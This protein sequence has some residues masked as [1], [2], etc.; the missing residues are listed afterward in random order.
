MTTSAAFCGVSRSSVTGSRIGSLVILILSGTARTPRGRG[1]WCCCK[2]PRQVPSPSQGMGAPTSACGG[3]SD[4]NRLVA[5]VAPLFGAMRFA[6]SISLTVAVAADRQ[7]GEDRHGGEA[8][9][10]GPE[11]VT[12]DGASLG[13]GPDGV[14]GSG[15]GLDFG[16]G[17][18][19][20]RHGL[21]GGEHRAGEDQRED[22]EEASQ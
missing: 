7:G 22:R 17:L 18:Q 2:P 11:Q 5:C 13:E 4:T 9:C 20:A 6:S 21:D 3:A 15:D 10:N 8:P 19:P 14:G 1:G 16:E 12:G